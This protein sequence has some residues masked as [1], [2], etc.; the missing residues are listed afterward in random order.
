MFFDANKIVSFVVP[1]IHTF[2]WCYIFVFS[3]SV[4]TVLLL[5]MHYI[6]CGKLQS[7]K[8]QP[9]YLVAEC[10]QR[11]YNTFYSLCKVCLR[12][13]F[14][15]RGYHWS[16]LK[17][18][19]SFLLIFDQ[20]WLMMVKPDPSSVWWQNLLMCSC[21]IREEAH[22]YIVFSWH[23]TLSFGKMRSNISFS[24]WW[25]CPASLGV[26]CS[27]CASDGVLCCSDCE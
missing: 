27:C 15:K 12:S 13:R 5:L 22:S 3:F 4:L 9:C 18:T 8:L 1:I 19:A 16:K 20:L 17:A 7:S 10:H 14:T 24:A 26:R 6:V 25:V 11:L 23:F 2:S 21:Y